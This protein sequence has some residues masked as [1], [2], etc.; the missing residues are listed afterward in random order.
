MTRQAAAVVGIYLVTTLGLT[1]LSHVLDD[2]LKTE[3]GLVQSVTLIDDDGR[4]NLLTRITPDIDLAF[5]DDNSELPQQFFEVHWEG[6]W[7]LPEDLQV[8]VHAGGDDDVAVRIDDELVLERNPVIGMHTTSERLTLDAGLHRLTVDHVQRRGGYHL[9]VQWAPAGGRARAFDPE[10][11]FPTRP[12]PEQIVRNQRLL[13]LRRL[14]AATWTALLVYLLW[15]VLPAVARFGRD[16]LPGT[17]RR[18]RHWSG[19]LAGKYAASSPRVRQRIKGGVGAL[20]VALLLGV[21]QL[22]GITVDLLAHA[23]SIIHGVGASLVCAACLHLGGSTLIPRRWEATVRVGES[24]A[25]LAAALYVLL[26]W[27]GVQFGISVRTVAM[28]CALAVLVVVCVQHRR[29]RAALGTSVVFGRAALGQSAG[30]V[31]GFCVLYILAYVFTMPPATDEYLPLAWTGNVDLLNYL[32]YTRHVL[33]LDL[34][35]HVGFN[36]LDDVYR[37]TPAAFYLLGGFSLFFGAD[38]MSAAMPAQ[39]ACIALIGVLAARV[40]HA[41]FGMRVASAL[42]VGGILI[43]GPFFRYIAGAY[44]LSTLMS[45]PVLLYLLWTTVAHRSQRWLDAS[46][47]VRFGSAYVLLLFIYPFLFFVGLAVQVGAVVL[48]FAADLKP[49]DSTWSP[50][51]SAGIRA[52]RT[53]CAILAPLGVLALGLSQRLGWVVDMITGLSQPGVAGWP[54]DI[55]SPQLILGLPGTFADVGQV[56]SPAGRAWTIGIFCTVAAMLG[57]LYVG[58]LRQRTTPAQ[59]A[60]A[61]LAGV[62]FISYCAYFVIVGPSYQQWK[63]ASYSTLPLSFVVLATGSCLF[64]QSAA[65]ARVTRTNLGRRV[66]T[67]FLIIAGVGLVGENLRIHAVRDAALL[68]FPGTFRNIAMMNDLPFF[69]EMSIEMELYPSDYQSVLALHFL[70]SKRVHVVSTLFTPNEPLSLEHISRLRPHFIQN[71]ECQGIGHDE[72]LTVPDVGCLLLAPPSLALDTVYPFNSSFLFVELESLGAREP[73]GR[74]NTH[75]T[76][77]LDLMADPR[78][79]P[80]DRELYVNLRL[81]P[82]LDPETPWQRAVFSWGIGRQAEVSLEQREWISLPAQVLDWTGEWLWTL[83]ISVDL[84]DGVKLPTDDRPLAV[85]FEELSL[86]VSPR[87]RVVTAASD[88]AP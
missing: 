18:A 74:W 43:S 72:T 50:W 17:A 7:H 66:V 12:E 16:R 84:P 42:A 26:C 47:A 88:A 59:R 38:P 58:R 29:L 1:V 78:R 44:F 56:E 48:M 37:Q 60:L 30:W 65:F 54:L 82:Y 21:L 20:V 55:I 33:D 63:L 52:G 67:A 49:G 75:T 79:V 41:I 39:F 40:S 87:G 3:T 8:D 45:T 23:V 10:R 28:G 62:T 11:L 9:N 34:S 70:P 71:Y 24:P 36:Y 73:D 2:R 5:L 83:P 32:R 86:S 31:I 14:V 15:L 53:M 46:L 76:V 57:L 80:V 85:M 35:N 81:R 61:G 22:I 68:R 27:F 13:L 4:T 6:L 69:R 77:S 25:L 19:S 64:R 51:R